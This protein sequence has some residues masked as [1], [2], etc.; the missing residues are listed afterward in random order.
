MGGESTSLGG[1]CN[2]VVRSRSPFAMALFTLELKIV[3]RAQR[4]HPHRQAPTRGT[5]THALTHMRQIR[6][7]VH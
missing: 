1:N 4:S 5:L 2:F 6:L 7:S 3:A